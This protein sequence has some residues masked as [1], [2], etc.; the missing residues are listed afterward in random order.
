MTFGTSLRVK[1][2]NVLKCVFGL[3]NLVK[4]EKMRLFKYFLIRKKV[5]LKLRIKKV[6]IG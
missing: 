5:E 4:I 6:Q 2:E 3:L 1:H